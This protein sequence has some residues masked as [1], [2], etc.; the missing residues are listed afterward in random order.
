MYISRVHLENIRSFRELEIDLSGREGGPRRPTLIIGKNGTSKTSLL[1]AIALGL[2][3]MTDANALISEPI[4]AMIHRDATEGRIRLWLEEGGTKFEL[5]SILRQEGDKEVVIQESTGMS[6]PQEDTRMAR[7]QPFVCGYGAGRHGI[8]P[9]T[10]REY[11]LADAVYTLFDYKRTLLDPELT[12]RRLQDFFGT[13]GYAA[14]LDG[15]KRVLGLGPEDEI[16][17][18]PGGGVELSGPTIGDAV[19][20]EGWADGYR[21]TFSWMLDLYG[22]ALRAGRIGAFTR[23]GQ[24]RG[25]LLIDEIEQHL[26]P[27]M[28]AEV[29][30]RI[31]EIFPKV[32]LIATTHSPLVALDVDPDSLVV[33]RR[34]GGEVV[35]ERSVPDFSGYS[36]EDMLIDERLFDTDVYPPE[37][38]EKVDR[39]HALAAIPADERGAKETRELR[40]LAAEIGGKPV[41]RSRESDMLRD[42]QQIL[43]KHGL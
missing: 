5:T 40:S 23:G 41:P 20:L 12:L 34:E 25:I 42:L 13:D 11:R 10:G 4:G 14:A 30:P 36:A 15:V 35:R 24:I 6:F 26:H 2:C 27:S 19:R 8:G 16:R 31:A 17:L 1:R 39:Y 38:R 9:D 28:Q 43:E 21:M 3:D 33:L 37:V 7:P 22:R 18:P 29:L 32:Q